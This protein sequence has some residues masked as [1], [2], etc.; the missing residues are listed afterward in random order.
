MFRGDWVKL[1]PITI[2]R[3]KMITALRNRNFA[4]LWAGQFISTI[5]DWAIYVALPFYIYQMTSSVL[6]TGTMFLVETLPRLFIG[7]FA[8][9]LIDRWNRKR[10]MIFAD[11][12]RIAIVLLLL[13]IRSQDD[14]WLV[15]VI[16]FT[17]SLLSEFFAPARSA[18]IPSLV[19]K[20]KLSDANSA[21]AVGDAI[22]RLIGPPLGGGLMAFLGVTGIVVFDAASFL[23]SGLMT[24]L[25]S[26]Q[27]ISSSPRQT[28]RGSNYLSAIWRDWIEGLRLVKLE[29]TVN[30]IFAITSIMMLG[31]G[32]IRVLF[33]I[34]INDVLK[35][36]ALGYGWFIAAQGVGGLVGGIMVSKI[37]RNTKPAML[38]SVS[39]SIAG[40]LFL[41]IIGFSKLYVAISL[42]FFTGIFAVF[43]MVST[44][45][46]LQKELSGEQLGRV[47]GTYSTSKAIAS[48]VGMGIASIIG[49]MLG[50]T[51]SL[52][53]AGILLVVAG[54]PAIFIEF[55]LDRTT[56]GTEP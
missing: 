49:N 56:K 25:V 21:D 14:V 31:Q 44:R 3:I 16:G 24:L 18:I 9:V 35:S 40:I 30:I 1:N 32:I 45:T 8:G 27:N 54:I 41:V 47:F 29:H 6:A 36:D 38:I 55:P 12:T 20:D 53:V 7:S 23:L 39:T 43:F 22:T 11:F 5:G 2:Q 34:F 42:N 17:E 19:D 15:Y 37:M 52:A 13:T 4:L 50:I 28:S 26:Y 10:I 33:I 51:V 46:L 48:V